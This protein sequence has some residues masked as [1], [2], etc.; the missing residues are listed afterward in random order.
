MHKGAPGVLDP[1]FEELL[2]ME[3]D[4]SREQLSMFVRQMQEQRLTLPLLF[5]KLIKNQPAELAKVLT[6]LCTVTGSTYQTLIPERLK[7]MLSNGERNVIAGLK[8]DPGQQLV[9]KS[10]LEVH[11]PASRNTLS[12]GAASGNNLPK[13]PVAAEST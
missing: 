8:A 13:S 9:W 2:G 10:L 5:E 1:I 12:S 6:V 4:Y 3:H 11:Q 7:R